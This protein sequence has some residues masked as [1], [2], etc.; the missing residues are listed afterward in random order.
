MPA[1]AHDGNPPSDAKDLVEP[2]RD[3]DDGDAAHRE[4]LDQGE[5]LRDLAAGERRG[6]LVHDEDLGLPALTGRRRGRR[7]ECL[8][9]L[10]HL[11]LRHTQAAHRGTGVEHQP[12]VGQQRRRA[13]QQ[14]ARIEHAAPPRRQLT[15]KDVLGD[16]EMRDEIQ[17]LV[18]HPD[19]EIA[20]RPRAADVHRLA[21]EADLAGILA[22][23]AAENFHQRRLAGAV[24]A[25]QHVD[26]AGV[27]RQVDVVERDDAGERLADAAHLEHRR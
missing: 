26:V 13:R 25:E 15:Q 17:L 8:G 23:G 2:V 14:G 10:D 22:V 1:V 20:G 19:T 3:V 27:E 18:N 12:E 24:L 16:R 6:R 21:I 4:A 9:N 11:T 5:Q 7:G